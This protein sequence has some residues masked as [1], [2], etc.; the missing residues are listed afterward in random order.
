MRDDLQKILI[1]PFCALSIF[2]ACSD[3]HHTAS[4]GSSETSPLDSKF[5]IH[6]KA[7]NFL[8]PYGYLIGRPPLSEMSATHDWDHFS[9]AFWMPSGNYIQLDLVKQPIGQVTKNEK[10]GEFSVVAALVKPLSAGDTSDP[11]SLFENSVTPTLN[12][13]YKRVGPFIEARSHF[14]QNTGLDVYYGS[15][16]VALE[17]DT[18]SIFMRCFDESNV[19]RPPLCSGTVQD[20]ALKI[21]YTLQVANQNLTRAFDAAE[22]VYT[23]LVGWKSSSST[24][25]PR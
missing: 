18:I 20:N 23:L 1:P 22:R 7:G 9:F 21:R 17:Q 12:Y 16:Y 2:L 15:E 4:A 11:K 6:S 10:N 3:L 8:V 13:E 14:I 19:P 25:L 24:N 5:T